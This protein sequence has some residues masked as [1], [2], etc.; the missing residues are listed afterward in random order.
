MGFCH[1]ERCEALLHG[2]Q[3][4]P[5]LA[6]EDDRVEFWT[7]ERIRVKVV[8]V[9]SGVAGLQAAWRATS[10]GDVIHQTKR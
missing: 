10:S 7:M 1:P 5:R 6:P 2:K 9:G 3:V 4:L 8:V